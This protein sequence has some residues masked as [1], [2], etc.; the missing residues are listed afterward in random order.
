MSTD[1][2][3][4]SPESVPVPVPSP[5]RYGRQHTLTLPSG[6]KVRARRPSTF[7]LVTAGLFPAELSAAVWKMAGEGFLLTKASANGAGPDPEEFRRYAEVIEGFI[8]HVLV[9]PKIGLV[10]DVMVGPDGYLTGTVESAD[11][12]DADKQHLFFFGQGVF[13]GDEEMADLI[14]ARPREVTPKDV[15]PFRDDEPARPDPGPGGEAVR[16]A[17]VGAG[18]DSPGGAGGA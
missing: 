10:T 14:A 13:R 11:L 3:P 7:T 17:A 2:R 18:G 9:E 16:A 8:P 6:A 4:A 12:P 15:E 5:V 1:E